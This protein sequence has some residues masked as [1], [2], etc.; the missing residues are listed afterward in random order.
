MPVTG[1]LPWS[2]IDIG[3]EPDFLAKEYRKALKDRLSP[4]CG[5][6]YKK[7]LHPSSVAAAEAGA[8]DKLI[9]YD[10][11]IACDLDAM[12]GERLFFLRRMNAWTGA[13]VATAGEAPRD[14]QPRPRPV[15]DPTRPPP[16]AAQGEAHGYRLRYTKLGRVAYLGHLDLVRHLPRIFRRAGLEIYYSVGFHPKPDLSFGPAL[17]L[18]IPSLGEVM[19]VRLLDDPTPEELLRLL[20]RVTLDGVAFTG[21]SRVGPN[22]RALG[23]VIAEAEY[24]ARL[25][26]GVDPARG[27]GRSTPA[28]R[29]CVVRRESDKGIARTVEVRKTLRSITAMEDARAAPAPRLGRGRA[30][31]VRHHGEPGGERPTDRG[32][33]VAVRRRGRDRD[34]PRAAG[35]VGRARA[36]PA[37]DPLHMPALRARP[38][39]ATPRPAAIVAAP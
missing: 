6:P 38:V 39:P 4:P 35:A 13:A 16:R 27:A 21:A 31:L 19:D 30:A 9:C 36:R 32:D 34:R 20:N 28:T 37:I 7:L 17:G 18:G 33:P 29:R 12:K 14:P 26:A 22:D 24:L 1:R 23:R 3:L 10:C 25:P 15:Q 2:H 11:G 8:K 5:K